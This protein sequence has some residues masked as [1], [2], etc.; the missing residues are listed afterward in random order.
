MAAE[1]PVSL[2]RLFRTCVPPHQ[3]E[4]NHHPEPVS[5]SRSK[6]SPSRGA[7]VSRK[8]FRG[9]PMPWT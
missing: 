4:M 9:T 3:M 7:R 8:W 1:A 6:N 5:P 2:A